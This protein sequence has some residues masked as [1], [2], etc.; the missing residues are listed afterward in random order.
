LSAIVVILAL[1]AG[2]AAAMGAGALSGLRIG[3]DALGAELATYMGA[4]Y[5]GLAGGAAV[6]VTTT[7]VLLLI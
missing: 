3:K 1:A 2:L 7:L 4:L 5:G 6:V